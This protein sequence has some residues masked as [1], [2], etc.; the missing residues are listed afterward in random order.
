[1]ENLKELFKHPGWQEY[2]DVVEGEMVEMFMAIFQLEPTTADSF[3]KFVELKSKINQLRDITYGY[4]RQLAD[5]PEAVTLV[6]TS[7]YKRFA[8]LIKKLWWSC[9]IKKRLRQ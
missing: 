7:Y 9:W 2:L 3:I 5:N 4:E 6:D 1:M 8:G